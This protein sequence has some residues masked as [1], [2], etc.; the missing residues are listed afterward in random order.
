MALVKCLPDFA[1]KTPFILILDYE[2]LHMVD[3]GKKIKAFAEKMN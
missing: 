3:E 1:L 2:Q